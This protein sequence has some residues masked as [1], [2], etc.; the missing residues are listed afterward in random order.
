MKQRRRRRRGAVFLGMMFC[1]FFVGCCFFEAKAAEQIRDG[2]EDTMTEYVVYFVDTE[3][4][5]RSIFHSQ[6]GTVPEGTTIHISFP[7]QL[8]G[9]DGHIWNSLAESPQEFPV[10]QYGVHKLFI[11][12]KQG[13]KILQEEK[14]EGEETLEQWL[15]TSWEAD[16]AITGQEA[17]ESRDP[18]LISEGM[19]DQDRRIRNL[20]STIHDREWH[21][22]YLIGKN[23]IPQTVSLGTGFDAVY[24]ATKIERFSLNG[25]WYQ[26]VAVRVKRNWNPENCSHQWKLE[27]RTESGCLTEGRELWSCRL[28]LQSEETRLASTGHRDRTG[29]EGIADGF[30]DQ[31]GKALSDVS[32]SSGEEAGEFVC[33]HEGEAQLRFLGEHAYRFFCVDADYSDGQDYHRKAALFLCDSVIPADADSDSMERRY[34]SFGEN[35]NYKTSMVRQWLRE[36]GSASAFGMEPVSVGVSSAYTG[37]TEKGSFQQLSERELIR[38][39]IGYQKSEDHFF[40]LSLEEALNYREMLWRFGGSE[41]NNPETQTEAYAQG[42]YLRTP[43]DERGEDGSFVYSNRIY[44]VDLIQGNIHP[45][46]TDSVTYGL[47]PAF[48]LPQG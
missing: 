35:N 15:S 45:V 34:F 18:Y 32:D 2:T 24:S 10:Y 37:S 8:I 31:C 20:V 11:E 9:S 16:C 28:C 21:T 29:E 5:N 1:M 23:F 36:K 46:E 22:F 38:R 48:V 6:S 3:D 40:L 42:Y 4:R 47:R 14:T 26:V 33:W 30:C 25:D 27:S 7:E 19:Q 13:E 39:G 17:T 43:Y 12:F 41:S 44:G